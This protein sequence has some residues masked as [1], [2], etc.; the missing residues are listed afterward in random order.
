M[1]A[2]KIYQ[3][4]FLPVAKY[5]LKELEYYGENQFKRKTPVSD[6]TIGQLY[7]H[8]I[9][10]SY[11]FHLKAI[12]DCLENKNDK[13]KGGKS[14]LGYYVFAFG[15]YP[16]TKQKG[17]TNPP[18]Q[19]ESPAKAKDMMFGFLKE[20]QKLAN[21][22]DKRGDSTFK[23][24]HEKLGMLS[25]L[26]WYKLVVL[27]QKHHLKQK[28]KIDKVLRTFVKEESYSDTPVV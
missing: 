3:N 12:R 7:H 16:L 14:F 24:K 2:E 22:I 6:W 20:M 10:G 19:I 9:Q 5:L 11:D 4:K 8:L 17:F 28:Y 25:A 1:R 21:E 26:E 13:Q 27:H 18:V 15:S 23:V